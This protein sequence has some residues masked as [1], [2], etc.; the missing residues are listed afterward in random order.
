MKDIDLVGTFQPSQTAKYYFT[1]SSLGPSQLLINDE[2]IFE[3]KNSCADAMSFLFGGAPVPR[4]EYNMEQ[5]KHYKVQINSLPPARGEADGHNLGFLEHHVGVRLGCMISTEH[6]KDILSEAVELAKIT[7]YAIIFTGNDPSWETEG[8]DVADFHLPKQGSQDQL[9]AAIAAVNPKTIVV[10]STGVA[11]ALPWLSQVQGLLQTWFPGQEAGHAIVD[12]L[13]GTQNPEGHL[14]CTFPRLLEDCPAYGNFPGEYDADRNLQVEYKEGVFVGYRH[15]DRLSSDKINFPF[16]FGLSYTT[17]DLTD[18]TVREIS[19][20]E[21][22]VSVR[23]SNTG[24]L[25][26]AIAVQ[27]YVGRREKLPENPVKALVSFKKVTLE[28]GASKSTHLPV[29]T[30]D[31]G[32]WDTA[33]HAWVVEGG[34]Y[35]FSVGKSAGELVATSVVQVNRMTYAP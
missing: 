29:K 22:T 16:G 30:R 21:Y 10:N 5:G 25:K 8:Q 17:F 11:V 31:F 2:L 6:D 28:P 12:V 33:A 26:G 4:I 35:N 14:T 7:D 13:T 27:I 18:L 15:F 9:V 19:A 3:Q 32:F 23:V 1:L 24:K 20:D 34:E